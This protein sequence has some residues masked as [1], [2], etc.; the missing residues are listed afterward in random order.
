L[1]TDTLPRIYIDT[2]VISYITSRAS[3]NF[4]LAAKQVAAQVWWDRQSVQ[5]HP[6]ISSL[7]I[8]ECSRGDE[9]A[10]ARRVAVCQGIETVLLDDASYDLADRLIAAGAVPRSEP[11]DATH[12]AVACLHKA[13]YLATL[14]F[15]HMASPEA[16][17]KLQRALENMGYQPPL[18]PSV[19]QV[20]YSTQPPFEPFIDPIVAEVWAIKAQINREANYDLR[21]IMRRANLVTIESALA[22]LKVPEAQ[23][24]AVLYGATPIYPNPMDAV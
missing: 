2:T 14:N 4:I 17:F 10:A 23:R 8:T 9:D 6:F 3:G 13:K 1:V 21:E 7:V 12:I 11:E 5:F 24:F 18:K 15:S 22:S 20:T 16:K 19:E